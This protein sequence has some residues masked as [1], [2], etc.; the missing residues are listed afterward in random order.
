[1]FNTLIGLGLGSIIAGAVIA[2][3]MI[4]NAIMTR[5]TDAE[6]QLTLDRV[7]QQVCDRASETEATTPSAS[8]SDRHPA[9][10]SAR[11]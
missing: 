4:A 5:K 2:A 6:I 7:N 8:L 3:C 11:L 9:L 1:M 10:S